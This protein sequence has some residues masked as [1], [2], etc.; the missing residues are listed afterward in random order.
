MRA[1]S[2]IDSVWAKQRQDERAHQQAKLSGKHG[3]YCTEGSPLA[4]FALAT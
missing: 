3:F 1:V 2:K 4:A